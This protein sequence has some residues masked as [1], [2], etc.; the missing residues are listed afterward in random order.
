MAVGAL[1]YG[2]WEPWR[3]GITIFSSSEMIYMI[4]FIR[5]LSVNFTLPFSNAI[6]PP[7]M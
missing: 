6:P 4:L 5:R 2:S 1:F 7:N 3:Q